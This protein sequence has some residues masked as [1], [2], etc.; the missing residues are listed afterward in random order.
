MEI[1]NVFHK[2]FRWIFFFPGSILCGVA[3]YYVAG[4]IG[5]MCLCSAG[6][7]P[8]GIISRLYIL[9]QNNMICAA[10]TIYCA[11]W[12]APKHK[13]VIGIVFAT[14]YILIFLASIPMYIHIGTILNRLP[15]HIGAFLGSGAMLASIAKNDI[16]SLRSS[17]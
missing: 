12:I 3:S 2:L 14:G 10:V 9:I 11:A 8:D 4:F 17:N 6:F 15:G 5:V 16:N 13:R 1:T 7:A